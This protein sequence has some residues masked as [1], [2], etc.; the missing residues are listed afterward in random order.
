M[1]SLNYY[2]TFIEVADDCPATRGETPQPRS[3][4]PTKAVLEYELIAK[5][6]YTYT[7]EDVAFQTYALQ[8]ALTKDRWPAERA[9]FLAQDQACMRTSALGKRYGWGVHCDE[10]GK[11]ALVAL[12]SA[13]YQR[14]A[15]DASLKHIK[16]M[17][18]KRA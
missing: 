17:R 3:N 7:G 15:N 9:K 13:D 1:T 14:F 18:S 2:N 16:A 5:H 4:K 12:G 6:P 10:H 11:V 8:Q